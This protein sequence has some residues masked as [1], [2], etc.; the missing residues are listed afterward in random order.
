MVQVIPAQTTVLHEERM[1]HDVLNAS[2]QVSQAV[3]RV[4]CQH[5]PDEV[6]GAWWEAAGGGFQ[7]RINAIKRGENVPQ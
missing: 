6:F 1:I 7:A 4:G 3:D 2:T 5:S